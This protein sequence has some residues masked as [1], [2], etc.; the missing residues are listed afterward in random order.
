MSSQPFIAVR[1]NDGLMGVLL[2]PPPFANDRTPVRVRLQDGRDLQVP[3]AALV[4]QPDGSYYLAVGP[5]DVPPPITSTAQTAQPQQ[6]ETIVPVLAEELVVDKRAVP[7]GG[8]RVHKQIQQ[9]DELVD[10][11]LIK[12]HVDIQRVVI[13]REVEAP[14]PVRYE[15]DTTIIPLV[16]EVLVVEKRLR[17]KEEIRITRHRTEERYQ[18]RV[19]LQREQAEIERVDAQGNPVAEPIVSAPVLTHD[20]VLSNEPVLTHEPVLERAVP[21]KPATPIRRNRIIRED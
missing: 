8:V 1:G 20:P 16:E 18:E 5:A 4:Q 6:Q 7:T 14:L 10:M 21:V 2:D 12:E 3:P 11:P 13:N 15:G 9:H 19:V 17:L